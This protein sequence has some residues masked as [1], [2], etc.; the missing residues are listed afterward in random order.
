MDFFFLLNISTVSNSTYS[1][2]R[3]HPTWPLART[4]SC[5][6]FCFP[7][8]LSYFKNYNTVTWT[9]ITT[10]RRKFFYRSALKIVL[11]F[12]VYEHS[13]LFWNGTLYQCLI[14]NPFRTQSDSAQTYTRFPNRFDWPLDIYPSFFSANTMADSCTIKQFTQIWDSFNYSQC[15]EEHVWWWQSETKL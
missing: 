12:L 14:D 13:T 4:H 2:Y 9:L 1:T 15:Y 11:C 10:H 5:I 7:L 6:N 8:F 3:L